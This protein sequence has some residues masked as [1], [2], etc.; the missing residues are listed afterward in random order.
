MKKRLMFVAALA[1]TGTLFAGNA[2]AEEWTREFEG[3]SLTF[4]DV[5]PND[6]RT[7]Y[8]EELFEKFYEDTGIEV[9]YQSVPWDDAADKITVLGASGNLPDILTTW[10]GWLGQ[11]TESEWVVPLSDYIGDSIDEYTDVIADCYWKSEKTRYGDIYTVPDG[12]MVKGI[13][14]RKDWCEELGIELDPTQDWTWDD[15]FDLVEKL[16]DAEKGRYG[17]TYRGA[18]GG[19]DIILT[20][21]QGFTEG[22]TFDQD[23][24]ILINSEECQEA[25]KKWTD[26]Y[27]NGYAPED[28]INWGFAEMVDN[29]KG[30]LT[31]TL[32]ND[33]EVAATLIDAM[34]DDQWMVMPFPVSAKDGICY[35][36]MGAPYAYSMSS[37]CENKD[38]AW[39]LLQY[40]TTAENQADYCVLTG[41]IPIKKE[42][43]GLDYYSEDGYY[44][45]FLHQMNQENVAIPATYGPFDYT[46]LHQGLLHEEVQS[47]LLGDESA[48]DALNNICTALQER[49]DEYLAENPDTEI[50]TALFVSK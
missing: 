22:A 9:E 21:M 15:Y 24:K 35:N 19:F 1:L 4:L 28:S 17:A 41:Q 45:A 16:T 39:L 37:F 5:A 2:L 32:I 10:S 6:V 11:F 50:E 40:M 14:V 30:G 38:A 48:E 27:L 18:R 42:A 46:D 7:S 47:Y 20:Y 43:S 29:F 13:Y 31:G 33:S 26:M 3:E 25:F 8:Y 49:M 44:G 23:G 36:T 34:E 12:W